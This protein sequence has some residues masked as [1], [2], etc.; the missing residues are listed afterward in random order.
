MSKKGFSLVLREFR[1]ETCAPSHIG[2]QSAF[3]TQPLPHDSTLDGERRDGERRDGRR[4]TRRG[5]LHTFDVEL[6]MGNEP[7]LT[8]PPAHHVVA[9]DTPSLPRRSS[10]RN[11]LFCGVCVFACVF[12]VT[13][14][15][16]ASWGPMLSLEMHL[17]DRLSLPEFEPARRRISS[18][19]NHC[20]F[21]V[22]ATTGR[23]SRLQLL[24]TLASV[25]Q[26][27]VDDED[28][29]VKQPSPGFFEI[30]VACCTR[31]LYRMLKHRRCMDS[32][33]SLLKS[34]YQS[35]LVV[36]QGVSLIER[37]PDARNVSNT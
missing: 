4:V 2:S 11:C 30:D 15:L 34:Y 28:I 36:S 21:S 10:L 37:P 5:G 14:L 8:A 23:P 6:A 29:A 25:L 18:E 26:P 7:Q 33:N 12:V 22:F 20:T 1:P 13:T 35:I 17:S 31:E 27:A 19:R 9:F 32:W 16:V 24:V 3:H